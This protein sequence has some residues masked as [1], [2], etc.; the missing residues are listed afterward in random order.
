MPKPVIE[1]RNLTEAVREGVFLQSVGHPGVK[2]E[3]HFPEERVVGRFDH[4]LI[5]Q[6]ISN[7]VKNAAESIEQ[8]SEEERA[9]VPGRIDVTI[10]T[11]DGNHIVEII[12][13]GIGLPQE[14]RQRLLEPYMTTREKGTGLG[15]AIVGK[16]AEDHGGRVELL[17][18]RA[19]GSDQPGA[20]VRLVL[21]VAGPSDD[22]LPA[23]P[24]SPSSPTNPG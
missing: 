15:L 20:C 22:A 23:S 21:S 1:E 8:V 6:A 12:D 9:A 7:L 24:A 3:T 13:N 11:E 10:R 4:R 16:I 5:V 19:V 17:D 14:G 2:V 18:A